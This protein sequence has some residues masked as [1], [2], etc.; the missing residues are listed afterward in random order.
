MPQL[1]PNVHTNEQEAT[2][3]PYNSAEALRH[4]ECFVN[5]L[6][7]YLAPKIDLYE[8]IRSAEVESI[9]FEDLWMLFCPGVKIYCPS[10]MGL[11]Y[12]SNH[13]GENWRTQ[14][15]HVPQV[16]HVIGHDGGIPMTRTWAS[17]KN[18]DDDEGLLGLFLSTYN[19]ARNGRSPL[20]DTQRGRTERMTAESSKRKNHYSTLAVTCMHMAF[21]GE[22]YCTIAD[23]FVFK[24]FESN[25]NIRSLEAYPLQFLEKRSPAIPTTT[26]DPPKTPS[27]VDS[28]LERGKTLVGLTNFAHRLYEGLTVGMTKE[29][30]SLALTEMRFL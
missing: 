29:E 16:Y 28:L 20:L 9:A 30:V 1:E 4:F 15:R 10:R 7:K 21:N 22:T 19:T 11:A 3:D 12:I 18:R 27:M 6:H 17:D 25:V 26:A 24:P 5:F 14:T 13:G 8:K 23:A 2:R